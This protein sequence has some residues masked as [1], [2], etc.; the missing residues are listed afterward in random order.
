MKSNKIQK[1]SK[2][3]NKQ[4]ILTKKRVETRVYLWRLN[5]AQDW[6]SFKSRETRKF[7]PEIVKPCS[8]HFPVT[9]HFYLLY[10][11]RVSVQIKKNIRYILLSPISL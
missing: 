10:V 7:V 5:T 1:T 2:Q 8:S 3:T 6:S 11:G 4:T 9:H